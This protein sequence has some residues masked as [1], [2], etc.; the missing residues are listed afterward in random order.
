[1]RTEDIHQANRVG[2]NE[3]AQA[4][5]DDLQD[6]IEFLRTGGAN[7]CPP[8]YAYLQDLQSWCRRAI[9]LQC[10]GGT[11]TLSLVNLGAHEVI[12]VDISERMLAVA[13]QK[14]EA[15][16]AN[17][18][19]VHSDVLQTPHD[20]DLTADL[21]YTGRGALCWI[22]DI[23]AWA[24]V[25]ARLLRPKGRLYVFE[26]HPFSTLWSLESD[27]FELDPEFGDYFNKEPLADAGWPE[28]YIGD[29]GKPKQ[30]HATK[31]ERQ[32]TLGDIVNAVISAGLTIQRLEEHPDSFWNS[33]PN[34]SPEEL[35]K[36]PQTFS[37]SAIKL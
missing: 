37:L 27:H 13:R 14:S 11:D 26:G 31:Y 17:A 29:L 18:S 21:V 15:L 22:M 25:V 24:K 9:H 7:F 4:Y 10:A 35:K 2:W 8:E 12:G 34:M 36:I 28:T 23:E 30:E 16:G 33:H 5:E 6:R 1:M 3:G 32:W 20:L 19:W